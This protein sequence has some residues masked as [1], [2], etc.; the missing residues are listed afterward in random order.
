MSAERDEKT[1]TVTQVVFSN[2]YFL[3]LLATLSWGGNAVAGRVAS[4]DWLPF[5]I[6]TLRWAIVAVII[7]PFVHR[8]VRQEWPVIRSNWFL[9]FALGGLGVGTFNL[10][11]YLA[12][13]YTTAIN[14]SILQAAMPVLIIFANFVVLGQRVLV[15]QIIGL[16]IA[17][18]GVI[19]TATSGK[20][21]S[22]FT[23]GLN[24]GDLIMILASA[25]YAAYSFGLRWKPA[26]SW[27][28]FMMVL[29][30]SAM[31]VS[32][33]FT[34]WELS[35]NHQ[36]D[37]GLNGWLVLGF[38]VVFPSI[39][40]QLFFARGVELIGANRAGQFINLV[41]I[42]GALLAVLLLREAFQWF[43]AVGLALVMAGIAL[44]EKKR[45][46]N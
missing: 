16:A 44:A 35:N 1:T 29:S 11:M 39:I 20:P 32:L 33:P 21:L 23:T 40:G 13:N 38:V 31:V 7:I 34:A 18:A 30:I 6:T 22:F 9:L 42:F 4:N 2:A 14:V 28:S 15:L 24:R 26:I 25:F 46:K 8:Q 43:H 5:T 10:L 12:L 37:P 36:G 45:A 41:P 17:I 27:Q 3:L 19:V